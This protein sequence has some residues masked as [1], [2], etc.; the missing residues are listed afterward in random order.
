MSIYKLYGAGTGGTENSIANLDVQFDGTIVAF[1]VTAMGDLDADAENFN[2]EVSFL[3]TNTISSNDA[4]GSI[5]V[6]NAQ[7]SNTVN[8]V[9]QQ[10]SVSGVSIPVIAGERIHLHISATAGVTTAVHCY[11]YVTDGQPPEVRRRR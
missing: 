6:L 8:T 9:S 4:R 5:V 1:H 11:L 7:T 2:I 10:S 3:S